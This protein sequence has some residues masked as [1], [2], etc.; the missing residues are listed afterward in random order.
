M[1]SC[2][3][4]GRVAALFQFGPEQ[5]EPEGVVVS[6]RCVV[7][8]LSVARIGAAGDEQARQGFGLRVCGLGAFAAADGAGE[9]GEA[10]EIAC[11]DEAR[12]GAGVEQECGYR[13]RVGD[14][15]NGKACIGEAR[16]R[17]PAVEFVAMR[18]EGRVLCEE[19]PHGVDVV[20]ENGGVDVLAR[21]PGMAFEQARGE[22]ASRGAVALI[23]A[24]FFRSR[25]G[26][27]SVDAFLEEEFDAFGMAARAV[28]DL[29]FQ[30][31]PGGKAVLARQR[32]LHLAQFWRARAIG[33]DGAEAG[34]GVMIAGGDGFEPA[35]C[36]AA[37]RIE[38]RIG[39]ERARHGDLSSE[40]RLMSASQAG[41][42]LR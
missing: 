27:V 20:R 39:C 29:L 28:V 5:V 36:F 9:H 41:R 31:G 10:A 16:E 24:P 35:L 40:S 3:F 38:I 22:G 33:E 1:A 8:R 37:Q 4:P 23:V 13:Q 34:D 21:D 14:C 26:P 15:R 25:V 42:R 2:H 32:L 12:I 11:G 6:K 18:R 7:E 30:R 17:R 19:A